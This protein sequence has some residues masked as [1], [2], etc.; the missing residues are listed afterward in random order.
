MKDEIRKQIED[1]FMS[2]LD[3]IDL[4][5]EIERLLGKGKL[6]ET[7]KTAI[8]NEVTRQLSYAVQAAIMK[9]VRKKQPTLDHYAEDQVRDLFSRIE[10][11]TSQK[12]DSKK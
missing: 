9:A 10:D 8:D 5:A 7:V 1:E 4:D 6:R 3:E 11:A 12:V 2:I